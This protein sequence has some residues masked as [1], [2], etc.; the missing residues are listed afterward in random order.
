MQKRLEEDEEAFAN[1]LR[2]LGLE[3]E[4]KNKM[5]S[6]VGIVSLYSFRKARQHWG[7]EQNSFHSQLRSSIL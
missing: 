2:E 5:P 3:V 1:S 6:V 7:A 4:K